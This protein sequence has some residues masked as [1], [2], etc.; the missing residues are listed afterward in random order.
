[1]QNL[2]LDNDAVSLARGLQLQPILEVLM[3]AIGERKCVVEK[4]TYVEMNRAGL[5]GVVDKWMQAGL[6]AD[7]IDYR[8][9][10]HGDR[11]FREIDRVFAKRTLSKNDRASLVVGVSLKPAGILTCERL[12]RD[13]ALALDVLPLDLFDLIRFGVQLEIV[14]E[15]RAIQLCEPWDDKHRAGRPID[16]AGSFAAESAIRD[17][18][19]PLPNLRLR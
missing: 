5:G 4:G 12:L 1:M 16:Y 3:A 13:A 7:P 6:L 18:S 17:S 9:L 11:L 14:A 2:V 15:A 19:K 10:E 8:R